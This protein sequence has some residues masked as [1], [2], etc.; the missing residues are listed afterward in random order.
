MIAGNAV[1][2]KNI[3]EIKRI[4]RASKTKLKIAL[5]RKDRLCVFRSAKHIS[6]QIIRDGKVLASASTLDKDLNLADIYSGNAQAAE[7]V[8]VALAE[9]ALKAGVSDVA[10]DRSG[11]PYHGRIKALAEGARKV[12]LKF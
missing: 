2:S 5:K 11:Y 7:K 3:K 4:R 1:R 10:F 9:K 12:G 8:G 6:A